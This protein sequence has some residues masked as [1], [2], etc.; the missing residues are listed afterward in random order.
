MAP[1]ARSS[2]TMAPPRDGE[3]AANTTRVGVTRRPPMSVKGVSMGVSRPLCVSIEA[4]LQVPRR[5]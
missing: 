3:P 2:E 5:L 1:L 4:M